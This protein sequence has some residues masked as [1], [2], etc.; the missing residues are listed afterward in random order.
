MYNSKV[1]SQPF[2]AGSNDIGVNFLAGSAA[3][4]PDDASRIH[5]LQ[6]AVAVLD[7][8]MK[9]QRLRLNAVFCCFTTGQ[10]LP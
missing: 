9:F 10:P 7:F 3:V 6:L 8:L 2:A 4:D 5:S 1:Q